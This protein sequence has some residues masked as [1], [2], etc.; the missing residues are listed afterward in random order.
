MM[1]LR[2]F[3]PALA[4]LLALSGCCRSGAD[5]SL[6]ESDLK[7]LAAAQPFE[8]QA[9]ALPRIPSRTVLLTDFGAVGDGR[10]LCTDAFASAIEELSGK[11]GGTLE[12]PAGIWR[13]GPIELKSCIGIHLDRDAVVVFDPDQDLYPIIDTNFEGLDVRRCLSPL[14]ATGAHD[15]AITGS[16][17]FDGSGEYWREVK[18][19]KVGDDTWKSVIARGGILS[20][21]G[22][23]WY[24]DEGYAKAR[25]TAGSL[26]YP[27]PSLDENE[28]KTFLRPVL[29]SFRE[30]ERVL[31]SGCT[32]QNSPCWN[33]HPLW[34]KDVIIEGITVR[35]PH[36]STNGDGIDI[37]ACERVVLTGSFFDVGDDAI[38]IK[39]GKDEDGRRH[40]RKCR[41]LVISDC[42]VYH[43][44]GGFVV[45][46]EM[47]GGVEN[48]HVTGCRFIGTDVGLRFK[49]TRGRGGLVKDIW[50]DHI[51]MKDIVT[52][53]VIFNLYYAGVA[54]TELSNG[55]FEP[56]V[57]VDETTPEF[58][59][60][61]FSD[62][63]CAG[64]KQAVFI[65]GLPELPVRN[66]D[67]RSSVFTAGKGV[68][69]HYAEGVTFEDVFVNGEKI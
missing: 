58:R 61:H 9:P 62:I 65:N 17:V 15:I 51:Y 1:T 33:L 63:I 24:P 43:G 14:N 48:I 29:L 28:I 59:D 50:C 32:F 44:H 42:T 16:G 7:A 11:G 39:S 56:L 66:L 5:R 2:R 12:V 13:T 41:D 55:V 30:C 35:N 34:C 54:A 8:M 40:A 20:E 3:F 46:S 64:A 23:V 6:T 19:R 38:C 57:E 67:F 45:G 36:Y 53:G 4:A 21:D 18:R 27:D 37:E 68:E 10:S 52:Y 25:A 47:S 31:L 26:N 49:S 60:C 69:V 22:K